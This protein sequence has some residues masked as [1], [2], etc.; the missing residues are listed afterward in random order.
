M[1]LG[2]HDMSLACLFVRSSLSGRYR[3][4]WMT[5]ILAFFAVHALLIQSLSNWR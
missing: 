3:F 5:L 2:I 1:A 4:S